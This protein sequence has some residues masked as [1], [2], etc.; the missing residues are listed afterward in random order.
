[1]ETEAPLQY[2]PFAAVPELDKLRHDLFVNVPEPERK[3][4]LALGLGCILAGLQQR[5]MSGVLLA[6]AGCG[7]L[8]RGATG[9]CPLYH[10]MGRPAVAF[11]QEANPGGQEPQ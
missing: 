7:A 11:A 6:V 10:A 4:S 3:L 5:S 1:M 2:Q 9:H 8:Y